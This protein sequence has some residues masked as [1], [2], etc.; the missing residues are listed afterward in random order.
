MQGVFFV[1]FACGIASSALAQ[2]SPDVRLSPIEISTSILYDIQRD[3]TADLPGGAGAIVGVDGNLNDHAAIA[4]ELSASP[5]MRAAMAGARMSTGFLT[6]GPGLPGRFFAQ[7]LAGVHRG[8]GERR[9]ASIQIGVGAD[10]FLVPRGISFHWALDYLFVPGAAHDFA[11]PRIS[12][13]IVVGPRVVK[14]ISRG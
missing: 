13:G 2:P 1:L 11:G 5:R 6:E 3:G 10:V 7:A 4:A 9:G 8:P 14:T 12:A